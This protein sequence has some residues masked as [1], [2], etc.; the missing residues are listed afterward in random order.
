M[1]LD[2]WTKL[3]LSERLARQT[4]WIGQEI[5]HSDPQTVEWRPL[6]SEAT[7]RLRAEYC[8][9]ANIVRFDHSWTFDKDHRLRIIVATHLTNGQT[10]PDLPKVY[11]TFDV[12]QL[13]LGEDIEAFKLTWTAVLSRLFGWSDAAIDDFLLGMDWV[14]ESSWFLHDEPCRFLPYGEIVDALFKNSHEYHR[15]DR[16]TVAKEL[17]AAVGGGF[18]LHLEEGYDWSAAEERVAMLV[19]KYD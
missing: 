3:N 2:D 5:L 9:N 12:E 18:Y 13:P 7:Q 19:A 16:Q 8:D 10:I 4:S 15:L 1:Q 6:I 11:L 14:W 17:R